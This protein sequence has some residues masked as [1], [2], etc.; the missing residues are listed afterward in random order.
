MPSIFNKL[1]V[2]IV[3][4]E[5]SGVSFKNGGLSAL[6]YICFWL[7]IILSSIIGDKLIESKTLSKTFVRKLFNTLGKTKLKLEQSI[8]S[9]L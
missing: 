1:I 7:T 9:K 3:K 8:I 6:P 5:K 4:I 2:C